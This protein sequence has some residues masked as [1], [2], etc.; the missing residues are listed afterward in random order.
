MTELW[1]DNDYE[2]LA[3]RVIGK[4]PKYKWEIIGIYRAPNE[5]MRAIKK[6]LGHISP[7]QNLTR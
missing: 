4:D 7:T 3:D 1:V 2:I 6:L 5:D